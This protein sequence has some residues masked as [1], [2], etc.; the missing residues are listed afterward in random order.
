[1]AE[2]QRRRSR[3]K[4]DLAVTPPRPSEA[5]VRCPYCHDDVN[6]DALAAR[7]A[8]CKTVHHPSCFDERGGCSV[9]GCASKVAD[10]VK[11]WRPAF[12]PCKVCTRKIYLDENVFLCKSCETPHHTGCL[13]ASAGCSECGSGEGTMIFAGAYKDATERARRWAAPFYLAR[14]L[15]PIGIGAMW[16]TT[17]LPLPYRIA[18]GGACVLFF[19]LLTWF[20]S[21]IT[22]RG[23]RRARQLAQPKPTNLAPNPDKAAK[24]DAP[25]EPA[26]PPAPPA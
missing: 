19:L 3:K 15:G 21:G 23:R 26:P 14:W 2:Q 1:V 10:V 5:V 18:I 4:S 20:A 8:L 11:G 24:A 17:A 6:Q 25:I 9:T 22:R 7:C 16:A 12:A 13:E